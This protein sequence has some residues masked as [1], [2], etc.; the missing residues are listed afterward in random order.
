MLQFE[1]I[2]FLEDKEV[3]GAIGAVNWMDEKVIIVTEEE[4]Q[5]EGTFNELVLLQYVGEFGDNNLFNHDVLVT[6][7]Q[8]KDERYEIELQE[9]GN[10]VLHQLDANLERV[11]T[12]KPMDVEH[13]QNLKH[14]L[15]LED[16]LYVLK[17]KLE[18]V[19]TDFTVKMVRDVSGEE[20]TYFYACNNTEEEVIDLIHLVFETSM[21]L[22]NAEYHRIT[23]P[24][25]GYIETV[26]RGIL[27]EFTLEQLI[28]EGMGKVAVEEFENVPNEVVEDDSCECGKDKLDCDC[29]L[30]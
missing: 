21:D 19:N 7:A 22:N 18:L 5:V 16:N 15:A 8:N 28:E 11:R 25:Q 2:G 12:G 3:I 27:E 29:D 9:D 10:I 6:T 30:W 13:L 24:Y 1:G 14:L 4:K 26:A 20:P 17:S 23:L